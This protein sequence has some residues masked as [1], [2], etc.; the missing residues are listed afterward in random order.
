M[1][2]RLFYTSILLLTLSSL[3]AQEKKL[4]LHPYIG[5]GYYLGATVSPNQENFTWGDSYQIGMIKDLPKG[6]QIGASVA[7][8]RAPKELYFPIT[9]HLKLVPSPSKTLGFVI[10]FGYS[11]ASGE[12][13]EEDVNLEHYGGFYTEIGLRWYYEM[14]SGL[15]VKPQF[16]F[17]RQLTKVEYDRQNQP[18]IY[19][20]QNR[21]ALHIGIAVEFRKRE[22]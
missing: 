8:Q 22:I 17:S 21:L 18:E 5:A 20:V 7:L 15:R 10:T 4:S 3:S 6:H 1:L 11:P 12:Y 13:E 9:A 14:E 16:S 19:I 2:S